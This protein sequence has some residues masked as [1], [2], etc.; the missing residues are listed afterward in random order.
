M[1]KFL[2][3]FAVALTPLFLAACD[4]DNDDLWSEI[5]SLKDRVAQ[6]ESKVAEIN[7][8]I[9]SLAELY[10]EGA[11][12]NK[13]EKVGD[14][15]VITLSN[16]EVIELVQ[17]SA[18][19]AVIP[20]IGISADGTWQYSV[21]N[22]QTWIDLGVKASVAD[23]QSP[24][25]RIEA[26]TG[27]WQVSY[28]GKTWDYVLDTAGNKV[29]AVGSGTVTDKFFEDVR[30][31]SDR[32]VIVMKNG[33]EL[34][35]PI[36]SDFLCQIELPAAG[37]QT[38]TLGQT[39]EYTVKMLGVDQTMVTAP[40]GWKA[41]LKVVGENA[42]L[43]VTAPT[44]ASRATADSSTDVAVLAVA[45]NGFSTIAKIQVALGG[46][47]ITTPT[48]NVVLSETI[49]PTHSS[50][51]FDVTVQNADL[52]K[53]LIQAAAR[54]EP[55]VDEVIA[56]GTVGAGNVLTINDLEAETEYAL[57]VVALQGDVNSG[58]VVVKARTA[59]APVVSDQDY[60]EDW[61]SGKEFMLGEVKISN[62][63]YPEARL[64]KAS[65][66]NKAVFE[67]G[68]L[69]FVDNTTADKA[70]I[71]ETMTSLN[72]GVKGDMI[73]VGRFPQKAQVHLLTPELRCNRNLTIANLHLEVRP[74]VSYMFTDANAK[75]KN[76]SVHLQDCTIDMGKDK[77]RYV[78]YDGNPKACFSQV[79][80]DNSI[81]RYNEKAAQPSVY[82]I[83]STRKEV[84]YEGMDAMKVTRCVIYGDVMVK[85]HI[86]NTGHSEQYQTRNVT[87][88]VKG[89][90]LYNIYQ[91][92]VLTRSA[93]GR[94]IVMEEN[95]IY[96]DYTKVPSSEKSTYMVCIYDNTYDAGISSVANNYVYM[97]G[98]AAENTD[99]V[100]LIHSN[101]KVK[102]EG[103]DL[104][105]LCDG[106]M[107]PERN[108]I[109][110]V[111]ITRGYFPI[112]TAVV[113]NGAGADYA[114]KLWFK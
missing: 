111:D 76:T 53:Y 73:L 84:G 72:A 52:W 69:V 93:M 71:E 56:N 46:G 66:L 49:L 41:T 2:M 109:Q 106:N 27:F 55:S 20:Q 83:S 17:G 104:A 75:M 112:N 89:N 77:G 24:R 50:L 43:A 64:L 38:F 40:E 95:V 90:T 62:V 44:V 85:A 100:K 92:N 4:D 65:E 6:L 12:I 94:G 110:S 42:T 32:L 99:A 11:T 26:E 21:D 45:K 97:L 51:S 48:V 23:G 39:R 80:V 8:T 86:I 74:G 7:T 9:E 54:T 47:E 91:P 15:Y 16:G 63:I 113:T 1:K 14:K 36:I 58:L 3:M 70:S 22:G 114:T 19:E 87:V 103:L 59:A 33:Q 82:A 28:D 78:V 31:E 60:Y 67:E 107:A 105:I 57:Y 25:F 13:V 88:T 30:V 101:N 81:I 68:G 35:V 61:K 18:A 29:K 102:F 96:T 37:V 34:V 108:P 98:H 10:K 5:D 79:V